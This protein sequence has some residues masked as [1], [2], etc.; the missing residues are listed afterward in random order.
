MTT[1][2]RKG[3]QVDFICVHCKTLHADDYCDM[4][5]TQTFFSG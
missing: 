3:R 1:S 2:H 4:N 5:A